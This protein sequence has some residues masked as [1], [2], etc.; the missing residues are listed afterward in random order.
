MLPARH[1]LRESGDFTSAVRGP[2]ASRAGGRLLVVHA[3]RTDARADL[4][5]R[6]G[7]VVSKAVGN[8]V[9]R[10]RTKRRL[11]ASVGTRLSGIP[12][13]LDV[14]VRAN[15]AAAQ[16]TYAELDSALER[17]LARVCEQVGA[18]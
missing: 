16:A 1:R 4:P 17:Q 7:F 18:R 12:S 13:G 11:R 15:P 3:N 5:P 14:V 10:N 6:V 9:V 8:A 2:G